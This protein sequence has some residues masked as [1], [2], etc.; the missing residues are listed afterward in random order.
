MAR[1]YAKLIDPRDR[2]RPK[3]SRGFFSAKDTICLFPVVELPFGWA[4]FRYVPGYWPNISTTV[5]YRRVPKYLLC[6]V[7]ELATAPKIFQYMKSGHIT[8]SAHIGSWRRQQN[9]CLEVFTY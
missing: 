8:T 9:T 6:Y 5:K 3:Y 4:E 7:L 1:F 2:S